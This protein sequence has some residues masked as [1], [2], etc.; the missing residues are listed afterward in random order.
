MPCKKW[1]LNCFDF[2]KSNIIHLGVEQFYG[3]NPE[4][5][6]YALGATCELYNISNKISFTI[7]T[8]LKH[9]KTFN[10][11]IYG[12]LSFLK[13]FNKNNTQKDNLMKL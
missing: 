8:G 6:M 3:R 9:D 10:N 7:R 4:F 2:R 13:L 1:E 12:G 11:G 5:R